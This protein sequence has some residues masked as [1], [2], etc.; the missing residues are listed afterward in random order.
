MKS[1]KLAP[2][3][4]GCNRIPFWGIHLL[5]RIV[6]PKLFSTYFGVSPSALERAG[7]IDPFVDVDTQLFI[8]PVL[9]EKSSNPLM[10]RDAI[11]A[12]RNHFSNFLRL[13]T[14]SKQ[15]GD[16][17]W[18]AASR[19]LDLREPPENGLGYGGSGRSGSS[20]PEDVQIAIMRTSKEVITL[21]AN[22]PEMISLMGFF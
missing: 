22:D 11:G 20:R 7:L 17:A 8:D 10:A 6:S 2:E 9:L 18:R 16:A 5:A 1:S 21:G 12:F 3:V 15:E 4:L 14:I 13:L 19:L